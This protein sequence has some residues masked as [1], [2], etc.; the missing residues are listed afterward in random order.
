MASAVS[1][2]TVSA[3]PVD[4]AG[5]LGLRP[6]NWSSGEPRS[7]VDNEERGVFSKMDG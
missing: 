2:T 6:G 5:E 1:L 7:D 4:E 3:E